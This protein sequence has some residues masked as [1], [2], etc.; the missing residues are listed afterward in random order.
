MLRQSIGGD[1]VTGLFQTTFHCVPEGRIVVNNVYE[2]RQERL[3]GEQAPEK[4][5][6]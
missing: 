3:L 1:L 6:A 5:T 4:P 2:P